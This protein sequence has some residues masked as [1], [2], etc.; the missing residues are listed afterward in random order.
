MFGLSHLVKVLDSLPFRGKTLHT[1]SDSTIDPSGSAEESPPAKPS[2]EMPCPACG[3]R[4][5]FIVRIQSNPVMG[6]MGI[7][8]KTRRC[9]SCGFQEKLT[10]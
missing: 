2:S 1:S 10:E 7:Y 9:R 8:D 5:F 4:S 6:C 3:E